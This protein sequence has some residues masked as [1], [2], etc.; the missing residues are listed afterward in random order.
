MSMEAAAEVMNSR[1][2]MFVVVNNAAASNPNLW[3]TLGHG[4]TNRHT[5]SVFFLVGAVNSTGCLFL[6]VGDEQVGNM[7]RHV[8]GKVCIF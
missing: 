7:L 6:R 8:L 1:R 4:Y 5:R 3:P 2:S